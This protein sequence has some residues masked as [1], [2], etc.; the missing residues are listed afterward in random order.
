MSTPQSRS[1]SFRPT[2]SVADVRRRRGRGSLGRT[3]TVQIVG[4]G[5]LALLGSLLLLGV[6][7]QQS[8]TDAAQ[9]QVDQRA[10]VVAKNI[11]SLFGE[12]HDE[13]L[14]AVQDSALRD[15]YLHPERRATLR[16][17]LDALLLQLHRVYPTLIDEACIIEASGVEQARMAK[18]ETAPVADL[19]PDESGSTFFQPGLAEPPGGVYQGTPYLSADSNRWVVANATPISVAGQTVAFLHFEANLDAV[20]ARVAASLEPGMSARI[21]DTDTGALIADTRG[22][23]A[24]SAEQLPKAGSWGTAA[25]PIRAATAIAAVSTNDN[26][27]RVEVSEPT[28]RPFTSALLAKCALLLIPVLALA[29]IARRFAGNLSRPIA[30]ITAVGESLAR[31]DLT[32]RAEID[33]GDEIGRMG[34]ALDE[35]TDT[36]RHTVA[37]LSGSVRVLVD[38]GGQLVSSS[39]MIEGMASGVSDRAGAVN[40]S[41]DQVSAM[42]ASVAAGAEEMSSS[43]TEITRNATQA[44]RVS[45]DAVALAAETN[46]TV[47]KLGESSAQI[48]NIVSVITGI[49]EQT[50]LLALNATIEAARAG[51][52]GKGFAVVAGE[53]KELAQETAKATENIA[54]LVEAIQVDTAQAVSAID[55]IATVID[56][57]SG[58]QGSIASAVEQQSATTDEM[59]RAVSVAASSTESV[60][61]EVDVLAT[62]TRETTEG[63]Q[64]MRAA[65]DE[66]ARIAGELEELVGRFTV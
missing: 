56:E 49:A 61:Q 47:A 15:W 10:S 22:H 45:G 41:V 63:T 65:G 32:Q 5:L 62:G 25:G 11:S 3:L 36:M 46:Q 55:R 42:V 2:G 9:Q 58:Y 34:A 13:I 29:L 16:P 6:L 43:I 24:G 12:W 31:G 54:A 64:G 7:I 35:A 39:A 20:E 28:P 17:E 50:N 18:G 23:S 19:S 53:V 57:V 60:R 48:N 21:V 26:H 1:S 33:R 30:R 52:A 59:A 44:A 51:E 66:L 40:R 4:A 14:I 8:A 38:H 37:H 27:W